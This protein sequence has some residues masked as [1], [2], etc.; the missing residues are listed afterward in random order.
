MKIIKTERMWMDFKLLNG[1]PA[2]YGATWF[3]DRINFAIY[4]F[5]AKKVELLLFEEDNLSTPKHTLNLDEKKNRTGSVW[6][7]AIEGLNLQ[8]MAYAY[9]VTTEREPNAHHLLLDPYAKLV[10]GGNKW[11]VRDSKGYSP[12]GKVVK[13]N[14]FDWEGDTPPLIPIQ[15]LIIYEMHVRGF[16]EHPS[17]KVKI[18]GTFLGMI[19]RIPYLKEL[20]I[21]AVELMPIYEFNENETAQVNPKTK[22]HLHN[23]WGYSTTNFFSPMIRYANETHSNQPI[24]EFKQLVKELHRN[25]IEVILDVVYNHTNEGNE[26][27]PTLSFKGLDRRTY[28]LIDN[29]GHYMNFSGCGNT[30]N[31]NHPIVRELIIQSLRYWVT[32]M[33]VDG[34]RFDLASALTRSQTGM[35]LATP[36][37]IDALTKDPILANVK[38][39]A[40]AW[41]V[42]G[43]YQVGNF[44]PGSKR[45][46]E[47]N[48]RYR[49]VV[50]CFVKGDLGMKK[51][52]ATAICGSQ[53]LYGHGRAP[54]CSINFV[55]AHD[56]FTMNDLVSYNQKH[57]I[58]NGEDNRDGTNKNDSWNCGTEGPTAN[59]KVLF[60]RER[61][62]RNFHL[63][64]LFSLG[65]PLLL[66]GDE[67]GHTRH[68]NNNAWCQDNELNWFL[69]DELDKKA[70]HLRF[71]RSLIHFRK[72]C[73]LLRRASF[74]S[75]QDITWH[76]KVPGEPHWEDNNR[77]VIFTLNSKN[78]EPDLYVAFNASDITLDLKIPDLQNG[79]SWLWL[80]NTSNHSPDDFYEEGKRPKLTTP[81]LHINSYSAIVLIAD[82]VSW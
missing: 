28:Y 80:V 47:W 3:H 69:W 66:M 56:G 30:I 4:I 54:F 15:D 50:R 68:G 53:D 41:D 19:E 20:G 12:L 13:Q 23:Y 73:P 55:T 76:G 74:L 58:E 5:E 33:H 9:R 75:E 24:N 26:K 8:E 71:A 45:W 60:L 32:E 14:H 65:V 63:V 22:Q 49:D 37:L 25:G 70:G 36:P 79:R 2:P 40:E 67:Y 77:L 10:T 7:I 46:S 6:H 72:N 78:K 29:F 59:E 51:Y 61:Q 52:F 39:I 82:K 31:A 27:G 44:V 11:G 1:K 34:F 18:P 16:T 64:Q 17:S 35:P 38:L 43:L 48:G 42:G 62:K 21:N 81:M 57:N